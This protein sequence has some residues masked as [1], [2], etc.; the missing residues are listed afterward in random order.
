MTPERWQQ[1]KQIL[2]MAL[3]K[4]P[5][6]QE[7]Y[8]D[9]ACAGDQTLRQEVVEFLVYRNKV[10]NFLEPKMVTDETDQY[11]SNHTIISN[12]SVEPQFKEIVG[13][14]LAGRYQIVKELGRGGFGA[15]YLALDL[16]IHSRQVV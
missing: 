9:E 7:A 2:E 16:D 3:E 4:E 12:L 13:S 11:S 15:T 14:V 1:L 10:D 8:L 5:H 6:E